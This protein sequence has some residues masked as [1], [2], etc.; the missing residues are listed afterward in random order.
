MAG[1]VAYAFL[2]FADL[3]RDATKPRRPRPTSATVAG[4]GTSPLPLPPPPLAAFATKN[5]SLS[6]AAKLADANR[7]TLMSPKD[8]WWVEL[9]ETGTLWGADWR[10]PHTAVSN[11]F[12]E[13][14]QNDIAENRCE[15]GHNGHFVS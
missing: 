14:V 8:D 10:N 3:R 2:L 7:P 11:G 4:S 6:P 1:E 9:L 15:H 12:D 13:E 5:V